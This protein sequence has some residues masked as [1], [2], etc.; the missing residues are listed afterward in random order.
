MQIR[1]PF[2]AVVGHNAEKHALLLLAVEPQLRGV[3]IATPGDSPKS[4]LARAFGP[5]VTRD[6]NREWEPASPSARSEI[7]TVQLPINITDDRL[8]GG[9]ELEKTLAKG[10]RQVTP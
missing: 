9:L 1:F 4:T 7:D 8:L 10:K 5:L 6:D 3:L 2:A